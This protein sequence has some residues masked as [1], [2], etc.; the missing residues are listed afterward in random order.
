MSEHLTRHV[1]AEWVRAQR[2]A[3]PVAKL[4][5]Q[6]AFDHAGPQEDGRWVAWIGNKTLAWEACLAE[7]PNGARTVRRHLADLEDAGIIERE[8]RTRGNGSQTT[9]RIVLRV[10]A[11][12]PIRGGRTDESGGGG[13]TSP[14]QKPQEEAPTGSPKPPAARARNDEIPDGFPAHLRPHARIVMATLREAAVE[15]GAQD[16][17][18]RAVGRAVMDFPRKPLVATATE[19]RAWLLDGAGRNRQCVDVVRRYRDWLRKEPDLAA[20][21]RLADDGTPTTDIAVRG[22]NVHPIRRN[23]TPTQGDLL[24]AVNAH[25]LQ[26]AN[27]IEGVAHDVMG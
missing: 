15:R 25:Q 27:T 6:L 13:L 3:S 18:V 4:I 2:T 26:A 19:L 22:T 23:G 16:V 12:W 5:L 24:R 17:T 9:N 14:P 1:V 10:P 21:E 7:G 8:E 11:D 20:A